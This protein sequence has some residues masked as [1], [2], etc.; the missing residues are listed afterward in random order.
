MMLQFSAVG[1]NTFFQT[2]LPLQGMLNLESVEVA[3][4][5]MLLHLLNVILF[6]C[7][8]FTTFLRVT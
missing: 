3:C 6:V 4:S 8:C 1:P 5:K 7:T 2:F